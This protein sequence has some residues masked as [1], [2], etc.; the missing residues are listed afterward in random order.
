LI[1]HMETNNVQHTCIDAG[2]LRWV[3]RRGSDVGRPRLALWCAD[4]DGLLQVI[5][6]RRGFYLFGEWA[7][8]QRLS[9]RLQADTLPAAL[10]TAAR[11][12]R[13]VCLD[14]WEDLCL[15]IEDAPAVRA[16]ER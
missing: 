15:P 9:R 16:R 8:E 11:Y 1:D 3:G 2:G 5:E 10:N 14:A 12:L 13:R 4:G 7:P 6:C